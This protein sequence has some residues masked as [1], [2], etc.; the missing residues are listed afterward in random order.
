MEVV[1]AIGVGDGFCMVVG[2]VKSVIE[3]VAEDSNADAV[4][5]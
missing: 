5:V 2:K 4:W 3:F 1:E